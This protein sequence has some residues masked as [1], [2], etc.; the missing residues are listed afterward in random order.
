MSPEDGDEADR[1]AG[2]D[3]RA[4]GAGS[5][6]ERARSGKR[7]R[8]TIAKRELASLRSEKTIVL[9]LVIQLFVAGFSSFLVVGLVSMYDPGGPQGFTL[10]VAVTGNASADFQESLAQRDDIE[11]IR[12]ESQ[13]QA[14]QD[15]ENET[16]DALLV[17]TR[18]S[19]ST[20]RIRATVPEGSIKT[21]LIVVQLQEALKEYE[22][23]ERFD[24]VQYL[25]HTPVE[26]PPQ[27]RSSPYFGFTYTILVPMLMFLPVFISGSVAVD[28]M[29]E[30][31]QRGTLEL[32]RVSPVTMWDIVDA[33][34]LATASLAPI[35]ALAWLL[36]LGF[37]GTAV[38]NVGAIV[39]VVAGLALAVTTLGLAL[40]LLAP[41]RRQAQFLY[42]TGVL[43][44]VA[45]TTLLPEHPANTIARL[46]IGSPA[47][48]TW[49]AVAGYGVIGVGGYLVMRTL[50]RRLDVEGL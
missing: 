38:A 31:I 41:D 49:I 4:D 37:N 19:D 40:S 28:S 29:T 12:Y 16:V 39:A 23:V 21:T 9:A 47:E 24:R 1:P 27:T 48:T 7:P 10:E 30:E 32:L 44:I 43:S 50:V 18:H 17:T 15:F 35:Q 11:V 36:L 8:W 45:L 26:T 33:K 3:R 22:R 6:A 5:G 14:R 46:A 34:L 20:V 25:D 2:P 13:A 42:A